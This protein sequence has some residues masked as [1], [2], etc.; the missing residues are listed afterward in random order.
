MM[1]QI[2]RAVGKAKLPRSNGTLKVVA[3]D[4]SEQQ[5]QPELLLVFNRLT[6]YPRTGIIEWQD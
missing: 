3:Y 2:A 1:G 6:A 4:W 5:L